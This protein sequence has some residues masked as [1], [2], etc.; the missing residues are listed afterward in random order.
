MDIEN[1]MRDILNKRKKLNLNIQSSW[2][3]FSE[4]TSKK[5]GSRI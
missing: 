1:K 4:K 2:D 5:Q 3:G